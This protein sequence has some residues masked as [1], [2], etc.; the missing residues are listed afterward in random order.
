MN[1]DLYN[2]LGV[3]K[4][5]TKEEIK[6]AFHKLS[7][8]YHPDK[9]P[10]NKE[11][12]EKFKEISSA[13]SVLSDPKRRNEYDNSNNGFFDGNFNPNEHHF[14][15][16]F[17]SVFGNRK[18]VRKKGQ[19]ISLY[20]KIHL[21]KFILGGQEI[22]SFK[23]TDRCKNCNGTG[24]EESEICDNCNGTGSIEN[25]KQ[26]AIGY[27]TTIITCGKCNGKGRIRI[28]QCKECN[29]M[30]SIEVS[31]KIKVNMKEG[32]EV[33]SKVL[34]NN[35]G[36]EGINGGPKG[37]VLIMLGIIIPEKKN[38]T[39]KQIKVLKSIGD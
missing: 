2:I 25:R 38:L 4:D 24:D 30:G 39:K 26:T 33:N 23:F 29:G 28:S 5:A 32:T 22:I 13:Y 20:H 17:N 12:E 37:D 16:I 6:K 11:A 10:D 9:N 21:S 15:H 34:I 36:K 18:K 3:K 7:V 19:S 1:K 14:H 27:F 31:K 35:M 8:K